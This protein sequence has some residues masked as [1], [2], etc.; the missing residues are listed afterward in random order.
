M[1]R[2]EDCPNYVEGAVCYNLPTCRPKAPPT[3]LLAAV[4]AL[5][6]PYERR[7][8]LPPDKVIV[9]VNYLQSQGHEVTASDIP[10][11]WMVDGRELT[12][13]QIIDLASR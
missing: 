4:D 3:D 5:G 11:L 13:G 6:G 10:G 1:H 9:A 7:H 2:C 8:K 12:I